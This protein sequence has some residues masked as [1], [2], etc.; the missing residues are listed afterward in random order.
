M[1]F[2]SLK[3]S[4]AGVTKLLATLN[5]SKA[6]GPDAIPC[7]LLK[8]L[9]SEISPI[10]CA[11]FRQSLDSSELPSDWLNAYVTQVFKKGPRC[12][13]GN[14]RPVS[15]TC[16]PCK[17]LE[18]IICKHIR[19]AWMSS[20]FYLNSNMVSELILMRNSCK[21]LPWFLEAQPPP[22]PTCP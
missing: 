13:P 9:S 4:G 6:A 10:F 19:N 1:N 11:L 5:P 21:S 20:V 16:V 8:E 12:E 15:L 7:R 18:H 14:Y 22:V 3:I 2:A 17:I